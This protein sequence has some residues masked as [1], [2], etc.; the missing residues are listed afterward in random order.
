MEV[1]CFRLLLSCYDGFCSRLEVIKRGKHNGK[2]TRLPKWLQ[3]GPKM[4]PYGPSSEAETKMA[5]ESPL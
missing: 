3:D 1:P 5:Q 2:F 4:A